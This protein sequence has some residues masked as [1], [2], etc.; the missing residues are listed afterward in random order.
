MNPWS[1]K[2]AGKQIAPLALDKHAADLRNE[3][4]VSNEAELPDNAAEAAPAKH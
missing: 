2:L 1:R 3:S 4:A